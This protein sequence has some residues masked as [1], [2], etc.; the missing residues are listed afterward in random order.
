MIADDDAPAFEFK[1]NA[2]KIKI[3][4]KLKYRKS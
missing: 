3:K 1:L 4:K 2:E